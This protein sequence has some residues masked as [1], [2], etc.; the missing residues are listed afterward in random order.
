MMQ[1]TFW[2]S[3]LTTELQVPDDELG[4]GTAIQLMLIDAE[5][6][7]SLQIEPKFFANVCLFYETTVKKIVAEFLFHD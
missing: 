4:I 2:L 1:P 7:G 6:D 5:D 3:D